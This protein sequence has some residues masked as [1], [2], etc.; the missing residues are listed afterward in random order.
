MHLVAKQNKRRH[1]LCRRKRSGYVIGLLCTF[2]F[3]SRT[4]LLCFIP[5]LC[6]NNKRAR[7]YTLL[8][9]LFVCACTVTTKQRSSRSR[10]KRS[11]TSKLQNPKSLLKILP[12]ALL[13]EIFEFVPAL[14]SCASASTSTWINDAVKASYS[15]ST[16]IFIRPHK[17]LIVKVLG[18]FKEISGIWRAPVVRQN[19][20]QKKWDM[21][22]VSL[23]IEICLWSICF[24]QHT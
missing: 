18:T 2:C 14:N 24:C 15:R 20:Y 5:A 3:C 10:K 16:R 21:W 22:K 11:K 23:W 19:F 1:N 6:A 9:S 13:A 7:P 4:G 12:F 17:A 8:W